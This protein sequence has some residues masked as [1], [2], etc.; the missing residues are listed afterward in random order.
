MQLGSN[1]A[2]LSV[3]LQQKEK[4]LLHMKTVT[5]AH[6][7]LHLSV[8]QDTL[9]KSSTLLF[10]YDLK[11]ILGEQFLL[12]KN[13]VCYSSLALSLPF[14]LCWN[15]KN[16]FS[17]NSFL[18]SPR[19]AIFTVGFPPLCIKSLITLVYNF[20]KI[21]APA[22][23]VFIV[24]CFENRYWMLHCWYSAVF[25][26]SSLAYKTVVRVST[27]I[28]RYNYSPLGAWGRY[29][30]PRSHWDFERLSLPTLLHPVFV[31]QIRPSVFLLSIQDNSLSV[32][33]FGRGLPLLPW[34]QSTA[35]HT[36]AVVLEPEPLRFN[37]ERPSKHTGLPA[38]MSPLK[39]SSGK[40]LNDSLDRLHLHLASVQGINANEQYSKML[41]SRP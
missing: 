4:Q 32:C 15:V 37:S 30:K 22:C 14:I 20:S 7:T 21:S 27:D 29:L 28:Y 24:L 12:N 19:P 41:F 1:S 6:E 31:T 18:R 38:W 17:R 23:Y 35:P 2:A 16:I 33:S 39:R 34:R 40:H 11:L 9:C 26:A 3:W 8:N 13:I 5:T 10:M 25:D 36:I